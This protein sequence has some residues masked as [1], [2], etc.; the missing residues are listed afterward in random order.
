MYDFFCIYVCPTACL[1][2]V[3]NWFSYALLSISPSH[4][5]SAPARI[6]HFP[7]Y[8]S[9]NLIHISIPYVYFGISYN[10]ISTPMMNGKKNHTGFIVKLLHY[11]IIQFQQIA[12]LFIYYKRL[13]VT[14]FCWCCY[15]WC[16]VVG[17]RRGFF[18]YVNKHMIYIIHTIQSL[19]HKRRINLNCITSYTKL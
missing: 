5:P 11:Q 14:I 18:C 10:I 15:C 4:S 3:L 12:I 1:S 6:Y 17:M 13:L 8:R 16:M 7:L 9:V 2:L 19:A